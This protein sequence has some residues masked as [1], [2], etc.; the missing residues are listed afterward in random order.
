VV[1]WRTADQPYE[2]DVEVPLGGKAFSAM[3]ECCLVCVLVRED[4]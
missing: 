4:P 3:P 2:R 1:S